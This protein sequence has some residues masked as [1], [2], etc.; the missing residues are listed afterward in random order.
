MQ[1]VKESLEITHC[2][3]THRAAKRAAAFMR[4]R[5]GIFVFRDEHR[6][7]RL[8]EVT[9]D[10]GP[11]RRGGH[12]RGTVAVPRGALRKRGFVYL[13]RALYEPR[14]TGKYLVALKV[15]V[16]DQLPYHL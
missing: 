12:L 16:G 7:P 15:A 4:E 1:A 2:K 13:P 10:A 5:E 8:P 3:F 9:G 14:N 6:Q 11:L